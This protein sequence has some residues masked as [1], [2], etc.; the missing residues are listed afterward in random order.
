MSLKNILIF[1]LALAALAMVISL[2]VFLASA[3]IYGGLL[4][5]V[6]CVGFMLLFFWGVSFVNKDK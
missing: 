3:A 1:L 5:P 4:L 2:F 6:L